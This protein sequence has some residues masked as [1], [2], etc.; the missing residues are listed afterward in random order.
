MGLWRNVLGSLA[1]A[2]GAEVQGSP[3]S[4]KE[5]DFARK[6][7]TYSVEAE[8]SEALADL[9]LM[10]ST[11]QVTGGGPRAAFLDQTAK[12][13][14]ENTANGAVVSS[15]I[16]GDCLVVP[17]WN[18]RNMQSVVV[19]S[20]DFEV[21]ECFG[22]EVTAAAYVL[23]RRSVDNR[24]RCLMQA[25]ELVPY[26]A[27]GGGTAYANRY[28]VYTS[29]GGSAQPGFK[30]F[31]D[32]AGRVDE[33]WFVPNVDRLLVGRLRTHVVNP[34]DPN[35]VKG[36]PVCYGAGEPIAQIRKLLDQM[37]AEFDLSEK[38]I[39][40][41][42]RLFAKKWVGDQQVT[43]LPRGRDRMFMQLGGL[44]DEMPLKEWSPEIRYQAYLA[45]I[46]KQEKLVERAV[47]VS[48]GIISHP[49]DL[50]YQNVDNVRKSQQRTV[51]FVEKSR[52]RFDRM[53]ADLVYSWDVLA[54]H[55]G[56]TPTG[57]YELRPDWSDEYVETFADKQSAII[58][59]N[60]I[61]ATDAVDYRA[62]LF[63]ETY[64]DA[65]RRVEEIKS[66]RSS[67]ASV[68]MPYEG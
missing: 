13:F 61:G 63:D 25:V 58:A 17:S 32:W 41:D 44:S 53:M 67:S 55:Y 66:E 24:E 36:A 5:R 21:L 50:N 14:M 4:Q 6:G 35:A 49:D 7:E 59:G 1:E 56:I 30:G 43:E 9:M 65:R 64:D 27:A 3:Q 60:A 12:R 33:E 15:F 54:N 51:S 22:D 20:E 37:A 10:Y 11:M 47:G 45:A 2:M 34:L 18:G 8:V 62:W 19:P 68:L 48:A 26:E 46:D 38:A 52:R 28:R 16:S 31:E 57:A 40:A 39:M 42:K 23:A 29:E